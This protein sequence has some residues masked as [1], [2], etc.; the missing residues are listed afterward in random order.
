MKGIE[1]GSYMANLHEKNANQC[2][3]IRVGKR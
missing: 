3:K 2:V 1:Y